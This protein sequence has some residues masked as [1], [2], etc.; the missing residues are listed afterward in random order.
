VFKNRV[1]WYHS[2]FIAIRKGG[3]KKNG[4]ILQTPPER[5]VKTYKLGVFLVTSLSNRRI[6]GR[7][8]LYEDESEMV[9]GMQFSFNG[10]I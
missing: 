4:P 9:R 6:V 7:V 8:E 3:S 10:N 1:R 5:D 2:D